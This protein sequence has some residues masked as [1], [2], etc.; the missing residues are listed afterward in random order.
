VVSLAF[1]C[2]SSHAENSYT[3]KRTVTVAAKAVPVARA[4]SVSRIDP[5]SGQN[6]RTIVVALRMVASRAIQTRAAGEEMGIGALPALAPA[7]GSNVKSLVEEAALQ[8]DVNP[9][10]ID[11]VIQ[12]ESNYNPSAVSP[13]GAQGLMQ[14]MPDTARRFGVN[15]TFDARENI[16]GG[17]KYL[18]FLQE[19]FKDDRLAIAAYNAGEGAVAKYKN[20]PP[21]PETM[22]YVAEVGKRYGK[23]KKAA[24]AKSKPAVAAQVEPEK[25]AEPKYAPVRQ[26][27][28]TE[29]RIHLTTQ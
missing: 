11:S 12:V 22:S 7:S 18:K 6:V 20:V 29:G 13:K 24:E 15:N 1:G 8:Y 25:P 28:D 16:H 10:L 9:A 27:V 4:V 2:A 14:L 23:A 21:Y 26:Y 3:A 17:V 19:T 5:R